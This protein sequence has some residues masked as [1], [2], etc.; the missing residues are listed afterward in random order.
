MCPI[1]GPLLSLE[2][3][4]Q[5][6]L[7]PIQRQHQHLHL[8]DGERRQQGPAQLP[9]RQLSDHPLDLLAGQLLAHQHQITGTG[10]QTCS[11]RQR[12]VQ[13]E[14]DGGRSQLGR[15]SGDIMGKV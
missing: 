15:P 9:M 5:L 11:R 13:R 1:D 6:G 3:Q 14:V 7:V 12:A 4:G 2:P 10:R 8:G